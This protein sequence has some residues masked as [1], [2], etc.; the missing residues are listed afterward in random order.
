MRRSSIWQRHPTSRRR[1][2]RF[3]FF[4]PPPPPPPRGVD[5]LVLSLVVGNFAQGEPGAL[6]LIDISTVVVVVGDDLKLLNELPTSSSFLFPPLHQL[7]LVANNN[8]GRH[9]SSVFPLVP[10]TAPLDDVVLD[11]APTGPAAEFVIVD[12]RTQDGKRIETRGSRRRQA[13]DDDDDGG[14]KRRGNGH[15]HSPLSLLF[16]LFFFAVILLVRFSLSLYSGNSLACMYG[17]V[18]MATSE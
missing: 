17:E 6:F 13:D 15:Q 2:R 7:N 14:S 5:R 4:V 1:R 18:A 12:V 9:F 3:F 10:S 11:G 8:L 16:P